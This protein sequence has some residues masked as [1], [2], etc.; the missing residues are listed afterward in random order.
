MTS[1]FAGTSAKVVSSLKEI[2][3]FVLSQASFV[4]LAGISKRD[5]HVK[6]VIESN[7][8]L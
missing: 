8:V 3:V 6:N 5:D 4:N 1:L 7:Y 2:R